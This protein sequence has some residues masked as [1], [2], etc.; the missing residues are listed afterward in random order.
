LFK[1]VEFIITST[2]LNSFYSIIPL[3]NLK[4][5]FNGEVT[6]RKKKSGTRPV[7]LKGL[8]PILEITKNHFKKHTS[9]KSIALLQNEIVVTPFVEL[10]REELSFNDSFYLSKK[11]SNYVVKI[12]SKTNNPNVIFSIVYKGE[13]RDIGIEEVKRKLS[14]FK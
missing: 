14:G 4:N 9:I 7:P 13:R 1:G 6:I 5:Y 8:N 12:K 2:E 10:N 11:E 3:E